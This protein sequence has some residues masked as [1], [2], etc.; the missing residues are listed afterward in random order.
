MIFYEYIIHTNTLGSEAISNLLL[1][2]DISSFSINDPNDFLEIIKEKSVPFDYY[3]E[4]IIPEDTSAVTVN[5]YIAKNEQGHIRR[6]LIE[7][8]L[9]ELKA[10]NL[11]YGS[12]DFS[13]SEA[14]DKNWADNWKQYFHPMNIGEKFII[15]PSWESCEPGDRHVLEI[16]PESSFGTGQHETTRLCLEMLEECVKGG[17][18][19]LDMGCGSGILGIGACL[20]GAKEVLAVDIEQNA[21]DITRKNAVVNHLPEKALT[22]YTGDVLSDNTLEQLVRSKKYDIIVA[23]IVADVLVRM[24]PLFSD[25][26]KPGGTVILS[27]IISARKQLVL[28]NASE[29][30]EIKKVALANDWVAVKGV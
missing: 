23:N 1:I 14:D 24:M 10:E 30:F 19:I 20:I 17:E 11:P 26:L 29:Y 4:N 9:K 22:A 15:K 13:V 27:G 7:G 5:V 6:Q 16:D 8:G 28:D 12:L 18:S 21:V 25:I 2:N 3:E